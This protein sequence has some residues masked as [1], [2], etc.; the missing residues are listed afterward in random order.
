[1]H[2]W[3]RCR[4]RVYGVYSSIIIDPSVFSVFPFFLCGENISIC[5]HGARHN[6]FYQVARLIPQPETEGKQRLFRVMRQIR[7]LGA[8]GIH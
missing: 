4:A 2:G 6:G 5:R 7:L 8:H 3:R 1:M